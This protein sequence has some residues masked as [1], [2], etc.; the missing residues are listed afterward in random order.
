LARRDLLVRAYAGAHNNVRATGSF[1]I[2]HYREGVE[3]ARSAAVYIPNSPTVHRALIMNLALA[4]ETAE[5]KHVLQ[6]LRRLAPGMSQ[7]WIR[8]NAV[9]S[10][11]GTMKRYIEAFRVAGLK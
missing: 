5:A 6:K 9:W 1:A 11:A 3:F 2:E 10:S 7:D 4:G 8:Q